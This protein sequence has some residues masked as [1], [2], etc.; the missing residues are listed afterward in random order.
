M[1]SFTDAVVELRPNEPWVC[2]GNTLEGLTFHNPEVTKPTQKQI[3]DTIKALEAKEAAKAGVRA[4]LLER[5]GITAEE[6]ALL[7]G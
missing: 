7:L 5:L 2:V 3:N 6:A 1:I 4:A